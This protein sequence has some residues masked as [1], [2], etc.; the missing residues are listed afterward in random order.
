VTLA[1]PASVFQNLGIKV[2]RTG[3]KK[4]HLVIFF[5]AGQKGLLSQAICLKKLRDDTVFSSLYPFILR[6][7]GL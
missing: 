3:T 5:T 7:A 6:L 4:F 2:N 1:H